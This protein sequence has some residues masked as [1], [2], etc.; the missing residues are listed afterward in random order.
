MQ[1]NAERDVKGV[2][3]FYNEMH[4]GSREGRFPEII[5]T[6]QRRSW[7]ESEKNH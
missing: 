5:N 2:G 1:Y 3:Y 4:R 6:A 7:E